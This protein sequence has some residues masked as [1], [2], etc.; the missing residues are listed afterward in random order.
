MNKI[1][2][3]NDYKDN[4]VNLEI[5]ENVDYHITIAKQLENLMINVTSEVKNRVFINYDLSVGKINYTINLANNANTEIVFLQHID[6]VVNDFEVNLSTG[7]EL[8]FFVVD[9]SKKSKNNIVVNLNEDNASCEVRTTTI[10]SAS[11]Q[12]NFDITTNHLSKATYSNCV[13]RA[14]AFKEASYTNRTVGFIE[15]G[16]SHSKCH[17]DTKAIIFDKSASAQCDPVLLIDEYDVEASH[18][19]AVGQINSD[20]LYYLQSRGLT[21]EECVSLLVHGFIIGVLEPISDEDIKNMLIDV[22]N[23]ELTV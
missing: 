6:E 13:S 10:C 12:N 11:N 21:Y 15:K 20:D 18:A 17:Q 22:I 5:K 19:A 8:N 4:D 14:V 1:L 3:N 2:V 23:E 7:S 16:M 9:I